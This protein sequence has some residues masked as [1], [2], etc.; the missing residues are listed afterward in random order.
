M[1]NHFLN[2]FCV[3]HS[4]LALPRVDQLMLDILMRLSLSSLEPV[5]CVRQWSNGQVLKALQSARAEKTIYFHFF[6]E[7]VVITKTG[8]F[9]FCLFFKERNNDPAMFGQGPDLFQ[10]LPLYFIVPSY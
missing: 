9:C 7:C 2:I 10:K 5:N 6:H 4:V 8:V 3:V 1:E